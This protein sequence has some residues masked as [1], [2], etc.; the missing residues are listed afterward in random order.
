MPNSRASCAFGSPAAARCRNVEACSLLDSTVAQAVAHIDELTEQHGA[1]AEIAL[2]RYR[3]DA[4]L[5]R[6]RPDKAT[7]R[8][9]KRPPLATSGSVVYQPP[10]LQSL[11]S[12]RAP[13][14]GLHRSTAFN[15]MPRVF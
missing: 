2:V 13:C 15:I 11:R 1:P 7:D 6:F 8:K 14:L 3:T 9:E 5:W 10:H 4:D 12:Q